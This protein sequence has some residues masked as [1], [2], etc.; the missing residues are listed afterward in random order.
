[1]K[2]I[3]RICVLILGLF[4]IMPTV[5]AADLKVSASATTVNPGD[6]VRI[7]VN[8]NGL[9]GKF[10]I[11]NS[12]GNVLSGTTGNDWLENSS[13]KYEFTAKSVGSST[14]TI[15]ALD[16]SDSNSGS[17]WSG[18]KSITINVVKP[19]EKSTNNNLSKLEVEGYTLEPS[20][21]KDV[22][23]Y[24][25]KIDKNIEKVKINASLEDKYA[26]VSGAGEVEVLEGANKIEVVATSETGVS[27]T[28]VLNIDVKD[29][30]PIIK[31]IDGKNYTVIK[32]IKS[33]TLPTE[34][35]KDAFVQTTVNI[36][37]TDIPAYKSE[38][39]DLCLIGLKDDNG[40]IYLYEVIDNKIANRYE[41]LSS[42]EISV[43]FAEP[44][45][46]IEGY[47]K[48]TISIDG[49]EYIVYKNDINT[50]IYG[51]N[52]HTNED[53]WYKY[54]EKENTIQIFDTT[55][56]DELKAK[57]KEID[58]LNN[59]YR[60]TI[61][62]AG[63]AIGLLLIILIIVSS[64][65]KNNKN[66]P[67]AKK[68]EKVVKPVEKE[69]PVVKEEPKVTKKIAKEVE[70]KKEATDELEKI[71]KEIKKPQEEVDDIPDF[72]EIEKDLKDED[73]LMDPY[74]FLDIK[75]KRRS[76]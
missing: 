65:K 27:K 2:R 68:E 19:R 8:A 23:E 59:K 57:D 32:R 18:S 74:D 39:L 49:K 56:L 60:L 21:N 9:T 15:K 66:K 30:N 37:G 55:I 13:G 6:K 7:T 31:E 50:L 20:F 42:K 61:I 3:L 75:K 62:I 58:D 73:E 72:R 33:L 28:Y 44:K 12:N 25:V 34:L 64:K 5:Y 29:S 70:K 40:S 24:S 53:H 52:I 47:T 51:T 46:I 22:L 17:P 67:E 45:E 38:S 10:S 11:S 48:S 16:A 26:R 43:L 71:E 35:N 36:D 41:I 14:I 54:D 1:M 76:K 69:K 4:F 63:C